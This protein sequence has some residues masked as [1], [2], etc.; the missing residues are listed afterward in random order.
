[1]RS[2]AAGRPGRGKSVEV[3]RCSETRLCSR[4]V[5]E[6]DETVRIILQTTNCR[7][8]LLP[9]E[10]DYPALPVYRR[11]NAPV[12]EHNHSRPL[13][14]RPAPTGKPGGASGGLSSISKHFSYSI[15]ILTPT[16]PKFSLYYLQIRTI[17]CPSATMRL[18]CG[19]NAY[20]T[21]D[22]PSHVSLRIV[23]FGCSPCNKVTILKLFV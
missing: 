22:L 2:A 11:R 1:M 18:R 13:H 4:V 15:L 21:A 9:T 14:L 19:Y 20:D 3:R 23:S 8:P 16:K 6:P 17:R 10:R 5:N 7:L 12:T